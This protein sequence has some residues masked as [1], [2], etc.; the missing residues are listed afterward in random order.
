MCFKFL[1]CELTHMTQLHAAT[2]G[3]APKAWSL[4]VFCRIESSG[5]MLQMWLPLS[6]GGLACQKLAMVALN[7]LENYNF[8]EK[9]TM[10]LQKNHYL[11]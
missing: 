5:D 9:M 6:C 7:S 8:S 10:V 11:E 2:T 4:P 3:K 1:S